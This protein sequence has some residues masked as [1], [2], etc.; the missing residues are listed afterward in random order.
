MFG[1]APAKVDDALIALLRSQEASFQAQPIRFFKP[2]ES[3]RITA[4]PFV[5]IEGLYQMTEADQRVIVLIELMC[6][7]V[8]LHLTPSQL[9]RIG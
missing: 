1:N 4:A 2:G 3:V 5:G 8:K 9:T 6:K 7:S